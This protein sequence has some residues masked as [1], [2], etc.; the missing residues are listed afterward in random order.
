MFGPGAAAQSMP[1]VTPPWLPT[2]P[3]GPNRTT[4]APKYRFAI[5]INVKLKIQTLSDDGIDVSCLFFS[6]Y[7]DIMNPYHV[8]RPRIL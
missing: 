3:V 6:K 2:C 8:L 1:P 4:L 5:M 7:G